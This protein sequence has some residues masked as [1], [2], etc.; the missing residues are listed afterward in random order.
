MVTGLPNLIDESF[1]AGGVARFVSGNLRFWAD[2]TTTLL[3]AA[4]YE[5][6]P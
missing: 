1:E 4:G 5:S 2:T 3:S 6:S